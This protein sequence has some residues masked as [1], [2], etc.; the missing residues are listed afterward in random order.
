M[1]PN[2]VNTPVQLPADFDG[3]FRFTNWTDSDF[4]SK[5][6][7]IKYTFPALKTTPILIPSATPL[8][9]QSIRKKFAKELAEREFFQSKKVKDLDKKNEGSN[10]Q[11]AVTYTEN[12]LTSFI[13]KA[14][15]P[16]PVGQ[17]KAEQVPTEGEKR[18]KARVTKIVRTKLSGDDEEEALV[19]GKGDVIQ[20]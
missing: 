17:L 8:E 13:Q 14:L 18:P 5:W 11:G 20:G 7:G 10:F 19:Q 9:I 12:D 6:G 1:N 3:V 2:Q 15:S 16:L 4:E